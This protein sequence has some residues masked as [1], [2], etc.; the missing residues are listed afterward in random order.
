MELSKGDVL[1]NKLAAA[2][3]ATLLLATSLAAGEATTYGKPLTVK[4]TT[5]VSDILAHPE[6]YQGKRV[7][8]EGAVVE[9][10]KMRG[11]W[12]QIAGDKDFES[13][14]FKVDDGVITFP[15]AA[16]G[17]TALVEGVVSVTTLSVE[18][19]KKQ[20]EHM[21]QEQGT[22]FD[23]ASVKGPKTVV[24]LKGEGAEIR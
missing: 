16:R 21:A 14:R 13:I 19:Q 17:K 15:L 10:C 20:G 7:K 4:E 11:C 8:V 12:I 18:E 23:P 2:T 22:A 1:V 9:V 6:Q 24:M 3:T 5:R